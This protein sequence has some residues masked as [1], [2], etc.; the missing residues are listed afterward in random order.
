[1]SRLKLTLLQRIT[2]YSLVFLSSISVL[3]QLFY[4]IEDTLGFYKGKIEIENMYSSI[5]IML[6]CTLLLYV[7]QHRR[8]NFKQIDIVFTEEQFK[9]AVS[10]TKNELEWKIIKN[11][12][13]MLQASRNDMFGSLLGE[14]ITIVKGDGFILINSI[15]DPNKWTNIFSYNRN[16]ENVKTF[17]KN[18]S[19]VTNEIPEI[20]KTEVIDNEWSPKRLLIRLILYPVSMFFIFLG[21]VMIYQQ[22]S[23]RNLVAGILLISLCVAVLY[24]DI[25]LWSKYKKKNKLKM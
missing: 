12:K 16:K 18:L 19:E 11:N 21:V 10:R 8:L 9:E 4:V 3:I 13:K 7:I 23:F 20:K 24:A 6:I 22:I 25:K 5:I 2:H 15:C 1:M 14:L 17:L